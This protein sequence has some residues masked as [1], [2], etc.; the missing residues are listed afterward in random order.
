MAGSSPTLVLLHGLGAT[1]QVWDLLVETVRWSGRV[2]APDLRGHGSERWTDNYSF[3]AMA[4]DV[5]GLLELEEPYVVL[6]HSMGGGVGAA[7]AT[8]LFGHPPQAVG[9]IGVKIVWSDEELEKL[10]EI[11]AKPLRFFEHREEAADWFLKLSGLFG[12]VASDDPITNRGV[13][14]TPRGWRASQDPRSVLV[15]TG[16]PSFT[17]MFAGLLAPTFMSLGEHDPLVSPKD[18]VNMPTDSP[19]VFSGLGHNAMVEDP[20]RVWAW[21][22]DVASLA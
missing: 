9:T 4:S 10:P 16:A 6:G 3:G 11:A 8:G 5:A 19:H 1:G 2:V 12:V 13:L 17:E 22:R 18:H 15:G 14:N 20:T 21:F 7:L